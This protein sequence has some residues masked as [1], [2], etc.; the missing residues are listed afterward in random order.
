MTRVIEYTETAPQWV[1]PAFWRSESASVAPVLDRPRSRPG[2]LSRFV[3]A[4]LAVEARLRE[5]HRME[6]MCD[7]MRSDI[8]LPLKGAE[9]RQL[10]QRIEELQRWS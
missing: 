7:R 6:Q 8:G 10:K 2:L 5:A 3:A 4:V 9:A 1:A